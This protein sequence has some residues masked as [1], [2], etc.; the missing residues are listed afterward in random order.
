[1]AGAAQI[2]MRPPELDEPARRLLWIIPLAIAIWAIMLSGFSLIL[3]RTKVMPQEETTPIEA[4]LI[5][6]PKEVGGLQGNGGAIHP[7]APAIPKAKPIVKPHPAIH[8]KKVA[9][10]PPVVRSPYGIEK[11]T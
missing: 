11:N 7:S 8:V 3:M 4:R 9:P 2:A 10:A 6:I 1:M 5:E